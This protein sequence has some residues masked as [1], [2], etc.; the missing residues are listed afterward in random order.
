MAYPRLNVLSTFL[1]ES[2]HCHDISFLDLHFQAKTWLKTESHADMTSAF[3]CV[4]DTID[5]GL[6]F[7][8]GGK[9]AY[10]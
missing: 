2:T 4:C 6:F 9:D 10:P 5:Q 3:A 7:L 1:T 8:K